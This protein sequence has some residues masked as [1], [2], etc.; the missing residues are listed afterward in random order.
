VC[1]AFS[2]LQS[3]FVSKDILQVGPLFW[4]RTHLFLHSICNKPVYDGSITTIA[5]KRNGAKAS[6]ASLDHS[7]VGALPVTARFQRQRWLIRDPH[8]D[9]E[10]RRLARHGN[11]ARSGPRLIAKH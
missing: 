5:G 8:H 6:C 3:S 2:A 9:A 7:S 1:I 4:G 11:A 10:E